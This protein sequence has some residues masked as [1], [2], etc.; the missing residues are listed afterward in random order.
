MPPLLA[1]R[2]DGDDDDDLIGTFVY[3]IVLIALS[4]V[5]PEADP[6][7]GAVGLLTGFLGGLLLVRVRR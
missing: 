5:V 3:G 7:A 6:V 1:V 4:F 2:A